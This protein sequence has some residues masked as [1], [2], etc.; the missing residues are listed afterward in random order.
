MSERSIRS[1]RENAEQAAGELEELFRV[2]LGESDGLE[3]SRLELEIA[4][5]C[6][7]LE[8]APQRREQ[9]GPLPF[10]HWANKYDRNGREM[11]DWLDGGTSNG[12]GVAR[13]FARRG[14]SATYRGVRRATGARRRA[15]GG[16]CVSRSAVGTP[17]WAKRGTAGQAV[18]RRVPP[19]SAHWPAPGVTVGI[20]LSYQEDSWRT[21]PR[22]RRRSY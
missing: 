9:P 17:G 1:E 5:S 10:N 16:E 18:G 4:L 7:N 3:S 13:P 22:K 2:E 20:R 12:K 21:E 11:Y 15:R 19:G 6:R 8:V 14:H